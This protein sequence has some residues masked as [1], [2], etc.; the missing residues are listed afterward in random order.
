MN[1]SSNNDHELVG[2]LARLEAFLSGAGTRSEIDLNKLVVALWRGKWVIGIVTTLFAVLSVAYALHLP[3]Q[4]KATAILAPASASGVS[5]LSQLASQFGGLASLAGVSLG[6]G[7]ASDKTA[8]AIELVKSWGFLDQFIRDNQI[9]VEVFAAAGWNRSSNQLV[10]DPELY[11]VKQK[12][13]VREFDASQGQTAEPSSWELYKEFVDRISVGQDK[14]TSLITLGVEYYSPELAK[15]WADKLVAAINEHLQEQD[16][17]EARKS[18]DYLNRQI[19]QT[20]LSD[21]RTVFYKLIEEQTK[22]LMLTEVSDEY[23]LKTLS[24]AM[25]PE[26]KTRPRRAVICVLGTLAGFMLAV[27]LVGLVS[28]LRLDKANGSAGAAHA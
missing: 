12:K 5:G 1:S 7:G 8:I 15:Q 4:Y 3:N 22:S 14:K 25:V 6:G 27:F 24:S 16:S 10:I 18:I 21:M 9:Q 23:A 17:R 20:S 19:E 26:E 2:R 28:L 11:D 13:W